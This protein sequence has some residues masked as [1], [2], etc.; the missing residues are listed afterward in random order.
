M[1]T[2]PF[3]CAAWA[4]DECRGGTLQMVD[5]LWPFTPPPSRGPALVTV[6]TNVM[7]YRLIHEVKADQEGWEGKGG[8]KIRYVQLHCSCL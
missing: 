6:P 1:A 7:S 4:M 5:Y 2:I 3:P 8:V